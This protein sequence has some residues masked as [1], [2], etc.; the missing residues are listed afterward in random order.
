MDSTLAIQ[1][2]SSAVTVGMVYGIMRTQITVIKEDIHRLEKKQDKHNSL[3]ERMAV[4]ERDIKSAHY[5]V[6]ELARKEV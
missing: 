3:I 5:R 1:V 4:A 2:I 6:D